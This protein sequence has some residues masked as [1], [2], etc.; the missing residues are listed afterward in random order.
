M[1]ETVG[2]GEGGR[3]TKTGEQGERERE[4]TKDVFAQHV[5][6]SVHVASY[7]TH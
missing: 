1:W 7:E 4:N 3:E 2:E 6:T 5:S